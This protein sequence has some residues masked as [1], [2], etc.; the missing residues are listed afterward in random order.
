MSEDAETTETPTLTAKAFAH[1]R[2]EPIRRW[3]KSTSGNINRLATRVA[4]LSGESVNRHMI[5]RW[6]NDDH[7]KFVQPGY[8]YG[9]YLEQAYRDLNG[10]AS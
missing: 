8:G 1:E 2:L 4:E 5:G 3:A 6:L 7:D 10:I 9:L